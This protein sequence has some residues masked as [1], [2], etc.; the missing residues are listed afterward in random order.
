MCYYILL[1]SSSCTHKYSTVGPALGCLFER[2]I[3]RSRSAAMVISIGG[4]HIYA[5]REWPS[6]KH[7]VVASAKQ[8][9]VS[10]K[11]PASEREG[12]N[13]MFGTTSAAEWRPPPLGSVDNYFPH[14]QQTNDHSTYMLLDAVSPPL[15]TQ[16]QSRGVMLCVF[17]LF[18]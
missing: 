14:P 11:M 4:A 9:V 12:S 5:T 13:Q 7:V 15:E 16:R 18:C 10:R 2:Q 17:P 3:T 6:T 1:K 8:A